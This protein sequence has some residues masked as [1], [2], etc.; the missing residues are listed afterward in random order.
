MKRIKCKT[1]V[2]YYIEKEYYITLKTMKDKLKKLRY[3]AI[4]IFG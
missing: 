3:S 2:F 4:N 1:Q